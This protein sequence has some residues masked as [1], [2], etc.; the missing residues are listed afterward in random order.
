[1]IHTAAAEAVSEEGS[2]GHSAAFWLAH[3]KIELPKSTKPRV[4]ALSAR[5]EMRS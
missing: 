5:V 3:R 2:G 1:M 4:R